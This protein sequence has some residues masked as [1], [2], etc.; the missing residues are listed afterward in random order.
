MAFQKALALLCWKRIG[1]LVSRLFEDIE[2]REDATT[3]GQNLMNKG[4]FKHVE[5]R[6]GLLDGHFYEFL[7]EYVDKTDRENLLGLDL[8]KLMELVLHK[9][10][11]L[12]G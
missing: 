11:P 9:A 7:D 6:H 5:L 3:Y 10:I 1:I 4:L 2:T 8:R 12:Q